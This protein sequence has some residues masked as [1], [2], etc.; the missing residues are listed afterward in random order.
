L[1]SEE[2]RSAAND[3]PGEAGMKLID[4]IRMRDVAL[5]NRIVFSPMYPYSA[6]NGHPAQAETILMGE[7]A[8]LIFLARGML[9]DP[10]WQRRPAK[11]L[12]EKIE[13][14]VQFERAW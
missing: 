10:Y 7:Q 3:L 9:R 8:D 1:G 12:G 14:A 2:F 13:P 5:K 11:M 6:R 4:P